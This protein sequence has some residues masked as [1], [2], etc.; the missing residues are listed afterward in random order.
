VPTS[1]LDSLQISIDG[2]LN[3]SLLAAVKKAEQMMRDLGVSA[4]TQ[5]A[6]LSRTYNQAFG[7]IAPAFE[8]ATAQANRFHDSLSNIGEI[9]A[10]VSIGEVISRGMEG[11][12]HLIERGVDAMGE[13]SRKASE[14]ASQFEL[15]SKG[16][17]ALLRDQSFANGLLDQLQ[18]V[19]YKSPFQLTD[20]GGVAREL[21]GRGMGQDKLLQSTTE[22]GDLT[23]GLGGGPEILGRLSLAYGEAFDEKTIS[24]RILNQFSQAGVPIMDA[25]MQSFGMDPKKEAEVQRFFKLVHDKSVSFSDLDKAVFNLT[26]N[27]GLFTDG[28][29]HFSETF[30]GLLTTFE[31]MWAKAERGFGN[32]INDW[33]GMFLKWVNDS[34]L[35]D[36]IQA[37]TERL[38]QWSD[39]IRSFVS[40]IAGSDIERHLSAMGDVF[41]GMLKKMTGGFD[42]STMFT[43]IHNPAT[44]NVE[45][46]LNPT[47]DEWMHNLTRGIDAVIDRLKEV[48][49]RLDGL[50]SRISPVVTVLETVFGWANAISDVLYGRIVPFLWDKMIGAFDL[51]GQKLHDMFPW[52]VNAP[53]SAG[54]KRAQDLLNKADADAQAA[55]ETL[56]Q[57]QKD[58]APSL[59]DL[60]DKANAA[61]AALSQFQFGNFPLL[62]TGG[63]GYPGSS[64]AFTIFGPGAPGDQPG[65][66]TYDP[67]SYHHI[68]HIRGV[69]YH[70]S[71]GDS[72][73]KYDYATGHYHIK[74]GDWYRSDKDGLMHRWHDTTGSRNPSNEDIFV[75][76]PQSS[77]TPAVHYSPT[78]HLNVL[79]SAG[80]Q[81]VLAEH[82]ETIREHL[83]RLTQAGWA[84]QAVV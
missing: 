77:A 84:N 63:G 78:Y 5:S 12:V 1:K 10:G 6:I 34:S 11:A 45:E 24:K 22:L 71:G 60:T 26:H 25:L 28:M 14:A 62:G 32:I 70:L 46:V 76:K 27:G 23:A 7:P 52:L 72:A 49:I 68:G 61:A 69:P 20:L 65:Q 64:S 30:Q 42:P 53:Q 74:P 17:G 8:K 79:D 19:A 48:G 75:D 66:P 29:L 3:P 80:V 31:D 13:M 16:M 4:K 83:E 67:D 44:G 57:F 50:M 15:L 18:K 41:S 33:G 73:M 35:W 37:T 9:A 51:L 40:T 55:Q 47:G 38:R 58:A 21:T 43:E 2:M 82:G 36:S 81:R 39:S 54:D 56:T 59:Q